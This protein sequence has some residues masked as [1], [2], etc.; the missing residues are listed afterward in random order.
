[1][2]TKEKVI[3][4]S[5]ARIDKRA[6]VIR[7]IIDAR[8]ISVIIELRQKAIEIMETYKEDYSKI[9]AA[10]EPLGKEEKKQLAIFE[11]Q[12]GTKLWDELAGLESEK[13]DLSGELVI[14][15]MRRGR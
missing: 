7:A 8:P 15:D 5:L 4:E 9:A 12:K 3:R 1:M 10:I 6:A 11:K 14:I 13:Q 2:T